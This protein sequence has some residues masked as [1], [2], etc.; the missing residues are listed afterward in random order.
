MVC[1][2]YYLIG[3][4]MKAEDIFIISKELPEKE[5]EKLI[6]LLEKYLKS[7]LVGLR[8]FSENS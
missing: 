3:Q 1:Y 6:L 2:F 4:F 8:Y 7:F 5:L